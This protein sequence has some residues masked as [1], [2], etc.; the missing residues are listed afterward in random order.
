MGQHLYPRRRFFE[1][2]T[3]TMAS[4]KTVVPVFNDKH[5]GP[6]WDDAQW[7]YQRARELGI[8]W[9]AGSSLPVSFRDPDVTLEWQADVRSC[10]GIG[11]SGLDI[12]GIHTLEFLQCLLERRATAAQGLQ[13]VQCLP[14]TSVPRLLEDG[15]LEAELLAAGLQAAGTQ[16]AAV[17]QSPPADGAV[18]LLKYQDGLLAPVLM[19]SGLARGIAAAL[20]VAD[21]TILA[22]RVEERPEPRYP[23]FAYLL[24]GIEAMFHSGRPAYP[25]ERSLLMAGALDR[26]VRSRSRQHQRIDTPEL[27][28]NYHP[29]DYGYAPHLPL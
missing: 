5:P 22:T 10:V 8:P 17:L 14:T 18:F 29:V 25:V 11:Y 6:Q 15:T 27:G 26:L 4:C 21:G 7:M 3:A 2:I 1:E 24:K 16:L 23:H 12:Y 19:L 28:F 20:R 13:H 9:M